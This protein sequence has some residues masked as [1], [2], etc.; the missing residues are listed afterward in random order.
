MNGHLNRGNGH[1]PKSNGYLTSKMNI[2]SNPLADTDEDK[3]S[4]PGKKARADPRKGLSSFTRSTCLFRVSEPKRDGNLIHNENLDDDDE[5]E[6]LH[7]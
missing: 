7:A 4:S 1:V 3:V 2:T 5:P 6:Q